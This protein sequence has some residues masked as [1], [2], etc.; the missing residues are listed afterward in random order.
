MM[1]HMSGRRGDERLYV[2]LA[3]LDPSPAFARGRQPSAR[4]A[5]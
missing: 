5:D 1:E 2:T 3:F 4:A